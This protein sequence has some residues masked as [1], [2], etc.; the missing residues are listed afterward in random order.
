MICTISLPRASSIA[1]YYWLLESLSKRYDAYKEPY[2]LVEKTRNE[3]YNSKY[4]ALFRSVSELFLKQELVNNIHSAAKWGLTGS[5]YN[6][7]PTKSFY[8][9]VTNLKPSPLINLKVGEGNIIF[10][11]FLRSPKY[12]TV[13]LARRDLRQQYLSFAVSTF[14]GTY[15]GDPKKIDDARKTNKKI[16]IY[17][18]QLHFWFE[19]LVKFHR[20]KKKSDYVF[21]TE[22]LS[23]NP[24]MFLD[25]LGLPRLDDYNKFTKKTL[26]TNFDQYIN[27]I[28]NFNDMWDDF[29]QIYKDVL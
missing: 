7:N 13:A 22:D 12:V 28:D 17:Y 19:W 11:E 18:E 5:Q 16:T 10:D 8:N 26:D 3:L 9:F 24:D 2:E 20:I 25:T 4:Q 21:Y 29:Y 23:E 14:S 27:N 1:S 6:P 15:H